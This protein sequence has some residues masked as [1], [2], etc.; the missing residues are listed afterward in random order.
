MGKAIGS[1]VESIQRLWD[2]AEIATDWQGGGPFPDFSALWKVQ[3]GSL[4][5]AQFQ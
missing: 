4:E 5:M 2:L 3:G 1:I